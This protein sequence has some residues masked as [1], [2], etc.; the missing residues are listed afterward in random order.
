MSALAYQPEFDAAKN[1]GL[2]PGIGVNCQLGVMADS[3]LGA[4]R[5]PAVAAGDDGSCGKVVCAVNGPVDAASA[6]GGGDGGMA[7][8]GVAATMVLQQY[9]NAM[10]QLVTRPATAFTRTR[11]GLRKEWAAG[12]YQSCF[13]SPIPSC[14][15]AGSEQAATLDDSQ[16]SVEIGD[17]CRL[18]C[19]GVRSNG[20]S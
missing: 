1:E 17:S 11:N 14:V 7:P 20:R 6:A 13:C 16:P 12:V 4:K 8:S 15:A 9:R 5:V 18:D 19:P 10:K 3:L 2:A